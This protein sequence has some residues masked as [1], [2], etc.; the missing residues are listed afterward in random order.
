[1][2]NADIIKTWEETLEIVS[3]TGTVEQNDCHLHISVSDTEGKVFGGHLKNG[4]IVG[5]T[6]EIVIQTIDKM[7]FNRVLDDTGFECLEVENLS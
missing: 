2:A 3:I 5:I 1:M 4:S 7:Q 6:A